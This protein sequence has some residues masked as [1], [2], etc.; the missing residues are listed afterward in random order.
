[1]GGSIAETARQVKESV[2]TVSKALC[3]KSKRWSMREIR[4]SS[5]I[6]ERK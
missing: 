3:G 1:M 2:E 4:L 6:I 5:H